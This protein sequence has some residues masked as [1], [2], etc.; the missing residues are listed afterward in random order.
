MQ[1]IYTLTPDFFVSLSKS[2]LIQPGI[3]IQE[4]NP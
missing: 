2:A 1:D 3:S 4:S